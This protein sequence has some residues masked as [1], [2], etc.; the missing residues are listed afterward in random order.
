MSA[1]FLLMA[2][3]IAMGQADQAGCKDHPLF[4]SRMPDYRLG[5]CKV[6]E[7]GVCE[8][9]VTKGAKI[10]VEGKFTY[11]SCNYTGPR[12]NEPSALAVV[13]N[14]ENAIKKVGGT[15]LQSVPTWWVN[16]KIV[17]DG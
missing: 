8:F 7:F 3:A 11:L 6:E 9:Y 10:P 5:D 13:R 1:T 16:G 14:Y 15:I 2:S 4:P 17:K 12:A